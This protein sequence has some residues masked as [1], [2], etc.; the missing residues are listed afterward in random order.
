[1]MQVCTSALS[2]AGTTS[3]LNLVS[4]CA[5]VVLSSTAGFTSRPRLSKAVRPSTQ[6]AAGRLR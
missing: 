6:G 3:S 1:M 2:V 5:G 4:T